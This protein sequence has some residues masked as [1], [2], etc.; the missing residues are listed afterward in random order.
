MGRSIAEVDYKGL[1][2]GESCPIRSSA[3]RVP[4]FHIRRNITEYCLCAIEVDG[5][6]F[7]FLFEPNFRPEE[8]HACFQEI[9][10]ALS[11]VFF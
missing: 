7:K 10:Q 6:I 8:A 11:A 9:D 3:P 2:V 1:L 4:S 5:P